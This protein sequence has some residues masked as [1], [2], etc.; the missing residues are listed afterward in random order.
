M[1]RITVRSWRAAAGVLL[2]A[3]SVGFFALAQAREPQSAGPNWSAA[4]SADLAMAL[5][6]MHEAWGA[7]DIASLKKLVVGDDTLVTF[8]LDP[9]THR[10]IRL[11]SKRDLDGFVDAIVRDQKDNDSVFRLETPVVNCKATDAMG[12]CTEECTVHVTTPDGVERVHR[13]WST[14]TA[15]KHEGTWK[16][17]QWHMSL[18]APAQVFKDGRPVTDQK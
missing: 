6:K 10:P 1:R 2:A 8:E 13:L 17:V 12:V 16:W 14:A 7:G 4:A 3:G 18:A 11:A 5:H 9:A 15:V